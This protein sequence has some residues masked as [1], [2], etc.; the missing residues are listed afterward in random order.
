MSLK[1]FMFVNR[2]EFLANMLMKDIRHA[3]EK[4]RKK[5][6][7]IVFFEIKQYQETGVIEL[8]YGGEIFEGPDWKQNSFRLFS[9]TCSIFPE[10]E[11]RKL[12]E[13]EGFKIE[14]IESKEDPYYNTYKL[15]R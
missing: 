15:L 14:R 5:K 8:C 7:R 10:E 12:L 9:I 1:N 2:P 13:L 4:A 6:L 3:V 11:L